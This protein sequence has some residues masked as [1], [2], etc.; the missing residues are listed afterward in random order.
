MAFTNAT[1]LAAFGR[2][3]AS[4]EELGG[5][6]VAGVLATLDLAHGELKVGLRDVNAAL[7]ESHHTRFTGDAL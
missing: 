3:D 4:R 2:V 6:H 5:R 1:R 7:A